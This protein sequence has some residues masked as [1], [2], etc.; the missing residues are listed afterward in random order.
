MG[1]GGELILNIMAIREEPEP[2]N[3]VRIHPLPDPA[4]IERSPALLLAAA[5]WA[6]VPA[7][8]QEDVRRQIRIIA[9]AERCPHA[10][11]LLPLLGES[12]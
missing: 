11:A 1:A 8:R 2:G 4:P 10:L 3:I 9:S 7:D 5:V 12:A 6:S